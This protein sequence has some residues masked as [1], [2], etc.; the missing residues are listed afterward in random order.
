LIVCT[1]DAISTTSGG[2]PATCDVGTWATSTLASDLA[3]STATYTTTGEESCDETCAWYAFVCDNDSSNQKCSSSSQGSGDSGSPFNVNHAP[4]FT[5]ISNSGSV[6]PGASITFTA[7]SSDSDT[8][9]GNDQVKLVVCKTSGLSGT[10]CDGGS[11]DTYCT[12]TLAASN[13]NCSGTAPIPSEGSENYYPY[14]FDNH[15][16]AASGG[17]QGQVQT[18]TVG[19]VAPVVSSVQLNGGDSITLLNENATTSI[20]VAATITDNNGCSD[21]DSGDN[22]SYVDLYRS[23]V[24]R[25]SCDSNGEDND[26]SCYAIVDCDAPSGCEGGDDLDVSV[27]CSVALQYHADPTDTGA[28]YP[29]ENWIATVVGKDEALSGEANSSGVELNSFVA[30]NVTSSIDYGSLE[31]GQIANSTNLPQSV[32]VSA[33]GNTGLDVEISGSAMTDGAN[34]ITVGSQKYATSSIQYQ[35]G[36]ELSASVVE[37]EANCSKTTASSSPAT[38]SVYWGLQIPNKTLTGSYSGTITFGAVKAETADW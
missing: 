3:T 17:S 27:T 23:G 34:S 38:Q 16:L 21:I 6:N 1:S 10:S 26:N 8:V 36:A 28:S 35:N 20:S 31:V 2:N 11:S 30:L 37:L 33:T 24:G 7:T 19:N 29:D 32:T 12:S 9:G 22:D 15:D 13:P 18:F 5:G 4:T 25:A 14:I